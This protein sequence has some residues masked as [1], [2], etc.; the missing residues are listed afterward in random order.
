MSIRGTRETLPLQESDEIKKVLGKAAGL[1]L[2]F[3]KGIAHSLS[4]LQE[5]PCLCYMAVASSSKETLEACVP[6]C[7]GTPGLQ[8]A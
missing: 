4:M 8:T 3:P 7:L 5:Q 6:S 1:H 2:G